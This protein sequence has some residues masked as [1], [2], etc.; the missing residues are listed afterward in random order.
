MSKTQPSE[1]QLEALPRG[2]VLG[3]EQGGGNKTAL[4]AKECLEG[5]QKIIWETL[6]AL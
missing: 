1:D 2:D 4:R 3:Q 5:S 6:K